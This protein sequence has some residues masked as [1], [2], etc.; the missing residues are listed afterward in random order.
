MNTNKIKY[1]SRFRRIHLA[2]ALV[3]LVAFSCNQ[4]SGKKYELTFVQQLEDYYHKFPY[5]DTYNYMK[6]Y[7]GGD[8][9]KL[10]TW[11]IGEEPILVKAGDDRIVRMN[12]DTYYKI[13]FF[14]L[15]DGPVI[16]SSKFH[17]RDRFYSFQLMDDRNFNFKNVYHPNGT[18]SLYYGDEPENIE[19]EAIK[20]PSNLTVII[21]RVEV[22]NKDD[23]E[24]TKQAIKI[25]K[26]I[27][28]EAPTIKEIPELDLLSHFSDS[29]VNIANLK[30]DSVAQNISLAK[31]FV[32][33]NYVPTPEL[34]LYFATWTK[35]AWG[36]PVPTHST[37]E[38]RY[39]DNNDKLLKGA[40][41]TYTLT[42]EEPPVDAFWSVTAYD[43]ERGGFFH[44]NKD[45]RYHIN[46]T[47]VV[48]NDDGTITFLFKTECQDNDQNCLT[49]PEGDFD[50]TIRYYLPLGSLQTGDWKMSNPELLID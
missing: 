19:G 41:G 15:S 12:N 34:P 31:M 39:T 23:E 43:T 48:K 16:L 5:Q 18:F 47:G 38:G 14:D 4:D 9:S 2:F 20:S 8:A 6:I 13:G 17:T 29:L 21:V 50:L 35:L 40:K 10:N 26:G 22:K 49:I 33:N 44:P 42:T 46:N 25:F 24:D 45:D 3:S 28:I 37:Y 1:K 27:T 30:F 32:S 7:T 36:G 11:V